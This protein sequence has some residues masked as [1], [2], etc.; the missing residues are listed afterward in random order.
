MNV[1]VLDP[2][3]KSEFCPKASRSKE[4]QLIKV[5]LSVAWLVGKGRRE[6]GCILVLDDGWLTSWVESSRSIEDDSPKL[7]SFSGP[8]SAR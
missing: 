8:P 5:S 2:A 4:W 6:E 1:F 7:L 3:M